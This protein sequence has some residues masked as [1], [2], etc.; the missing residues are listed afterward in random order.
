MTRFPEGFLWGAA[1]AAHQVEGGNVGNHY[2][3]WEHDPHGPFAEP[4]GDTCDHYHRW[5]E[6]LDLLAAAGLTAYRFSL[7]WSRIEPE[8]GEISRAALD[9][10]RRMVAGCRDRGLAPVVTLAHFT[11]PRW[12]ARDGG[13]TGPKAGDRFARFTETVLPVVAD[14]GYVCTV[15]EPNLMACMPVLAATAARGERVGG[16]PRP[17]QETAEAL[18]ELHRRARTVLRDGGAPPSGLTLVGQE[19]LAED[20]AVEEMAAHRAA[21]EDQF[22]AAAADD[23]FVGLQ[24]YSCARI[25]PD[26]PVAPPD[27]LRTLADMEY[28]PGALGAAVRRAAEVLPGTPLLITENGIATADDAQRVAYTEGALRSLHAAMADGADVRGYLHWSLLDNFEWFAGYRPT[29]GLVAVDRST[30]RRTPKPSL[31][32]LGRVARANALGAEA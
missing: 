5:A 6:D 24:V 30:F 19:F 4:S 12:M 21:M 3:E 14:A 8:E 17:D 1:T 31:A 18:L 27:D 28:R 26:G 2:W 22:L 15:N 13:W 7:E 32:W 11:M 16:L 20:G 29:F 23:D 9:H 10:Y 25:G